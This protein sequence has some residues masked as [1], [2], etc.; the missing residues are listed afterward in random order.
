MVDPDPF[1]I[2]CQISTIHKKVISK[3]PLKFKTPFKWM[4]MNIIPATSSKSLTK[5]TI[6]SNYLLIV[7]SYSNIS[8]LHRIKNINIEEVMDKLDMFQARYVKVDAFG[9]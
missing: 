7:N 9:W 3:A 8:K 4:F 6:F 5:E 1:F 2:S